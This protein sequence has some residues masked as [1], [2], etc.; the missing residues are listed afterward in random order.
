[1]TT[2]LAS[3]IIGV[4]EMVILTLPLLLLLFIS[5]I[6]YLITMQNTFNEIS[7]ENRKMEAGHVWL[8]LIPLFGLVWQFI[9]VNRMADSLKLEF[10]KR[11]IKEVEDRPGISIGLTFCILF[12]ILFC[13]SIIPI[14]GFLTG[15]AGLICWIVYWVKINGYKVKLQQNR[16]A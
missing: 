7:P 8:T 5:M 10:A 16:P 13:S 11:N 4:I 15:I 2:T 6:F 3:L 9:I 1:M 12:C 14:L